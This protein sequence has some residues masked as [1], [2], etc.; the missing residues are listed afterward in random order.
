MLYFVVD[1]HEKCSHLLLSGEFD[2][3][4]T[5]IRKSYIKGNSGLMMM[6]NFFWTTVDYMRSLPPLIVNSKYSAELFILSSGNTRVHVLHDAHFDVG[7]V[8]IERRHYD[9]SVREA[10]SH[11]C[12]T[13]N[14]CVKSM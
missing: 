14:M 8:E 10:R 7:E 4:G 3:V 5:N 2:V 9:I 11:H 6:G 1:L 12:V 13:A